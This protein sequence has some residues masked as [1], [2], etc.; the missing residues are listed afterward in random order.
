MNHEDQK[1]YQ[2]KP[3]AAK[4]QPHDCTNERWAP[5]F[6]RLHNFCVHQA[7]GKSAHASKILDV[8]RTERE[9]VAG[10]LLGCVEL[11]MTHRS[12][13]RC[14]FTTHPTCLLVPSSR[15]VLFVLV[16]IPVVESLLPIVDALSLYDLSGAGFSCGNP[17]Q[18]EIFPK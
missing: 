11:A 8:S 1:E 9:P 5:K 6:R 7:L 3:G 10:N 12:A 15:I 2:G 17:L 16:V 4:P 14:V 13:S 18:V